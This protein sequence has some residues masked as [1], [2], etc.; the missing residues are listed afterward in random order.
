[1]WKQTVAWCVH[2]SGSPGL[3]EVGGPGQPLPI[4]TRESAAP[5]TPGAGFWPPE[6]GEESSPLFQVLFAVICCGC[7]RTQTVC[8]VTLS[9]MKGS[10][11]RASGRPTE[12]TV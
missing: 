11:T 5:P 10:G 7:H 9:D 1:M 8:E 3:R 2:N 4:D 6:P 12:G